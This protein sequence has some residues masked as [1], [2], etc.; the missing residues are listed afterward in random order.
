MKFEL[1]KEYLDGYG[2]KFTVIEILDDTNT[3][4]PIF[5]RNSG[6]TT[7]GYTLDG[8]YNLH[9][10]SNFDLIDPL[11]PTPTEQLVIPNEALYILME[12]CAEV[13]QAISKILRFGW[14]AVN[15]MVESEQNNSQHLQEEMGDLLAMIEIVTT[16]YGLSSEAIE[17]AKL[18]K[19]NK[20]KKWSNLF[21]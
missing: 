19:I 1:G 16:K 2:D 3:P 10:P 5:A 14:E 21:K 18:N 20:L 17:D 8:F 12:E 6:G 13:T 11:L 9:Q 15:P 7:Y 4:Y